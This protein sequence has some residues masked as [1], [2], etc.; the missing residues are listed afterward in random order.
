MFWEFPID[1][2][3]KYWD[4]FVAKP[5]VLH[6][7]DPSGVP[8]FI[9]RGWTGTL[10]AILGPWAA[11][12]ATTLIGFA[13]Y[14]RLALDILHWMEDKN[15]Q[16]EY[17]RRLSR[18]SSASSESDP[19]RV[20]RIMLEFLVILT[21]GATAWF[22]AGPMPEVLAIL[23]RLEFPALLKLLVELLVNGQCQ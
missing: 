19:G 17:G 2:P 10:V 20:P 14:C 13:F 22:D 18:A 3:H 23:A 7:G 12:V 1:D 5:T 15:F 8:M 6:L 11:R 9:V 4:D 16:H 21:A